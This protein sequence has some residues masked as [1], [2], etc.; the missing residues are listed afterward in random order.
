M[1]TITPYT[2]GLVVPQYKTTDYN[3]DLEMQLLVKKQGEYNQVMSTLN[4]LQNTSLNISMLNMKGKEKLDQY[5]QELDDLFSKDLGDLTDPAIQAKLAGYF[6]KISGDSDL[7]RRSKLSQHYQTQLN[8]IE[9]MRNAKNPAKSGYNAINEAVFKKWTGGLEDFMTADS[10]D[11]WES[12]MQSYTPFKDIDQKMVNLTKLLHEESKISQKPVTKKVTVDGKEY[13]VYTG[14]NVLDSETGVSPQRIRQLLETTLDGDEIAQLDVL[15]KYRILQNDTPEGKANLY[16]N[17]NGWLEREHKTT[18]RQLAKIKALKKQLDPANI[19]ASLSDDEKL[20]RKAQYETELENLTDQ[21]EYL[22]KKIT[23]QV[24]NQFSPTQWAEMS[25]DEILPFM[26]QLT[27]EN[28]VNGISEAL[29]WKSTIDK[30]GTDQTYFAQKRIENMEQ[31]L[32]LDEKLGMAKLKLAEMKLAAELGKSGENAWTSPGDIIKSPEE[33][34]SSWDKFTEIQGEYAD[35]TTPVV[36]SKD[37]EGNYTIDPKNLTSNSWIKNHADNHEVKLWS[38]YMS[39]YRNKGAFL[40]DNKTQPNIAG[41][42]LF[43]K[44]L[45]NGEFKNDKYLDGLWDQYEAEQD[46]ANWL[47]DKSDRVASVVLESSNYQNTTLPGGKYSLQDYAEANGWNSGKGEM[48]FGIP[49]GKGG[50]KQMT[51]TEVKKEYQKYKN[52]DTPRNTIRPANTTNPLGAL[53]DIYQDFSNALDP[54]INTSYKGILINDPEFLKLVGRAMEAETMSQETIQQAFVD[55]L[56]QWVQGKQQQTSDSKVIS[57]NI[58]RINEGLKLINPD[59]ATGL[60]PDDITSISRPFGLGEFGYFQVSASA[61]KNLGDKE[62][63]NNN[64]E[65]VPVQTNEWYRY[66]VPAVNR[67]DLIANAMF[68]DKGEVSRNIN[69]YKIT[70]SDSPASPDTFTLEI[71]GNGMNH[72]EYVAKKDITQIFALAEQYINTLKK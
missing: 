33:M 7:K 22:T 57:E 50:H 46:I 26:R 16:S 10:V 14:Y 38:A 72:S 59:F 11:N 51:W 35:R 12:V 27:I 71:T 1:P 55:E 64:G 69:G 44:Q 6:T 70:I 49:D 62:L 13:E 36:T 43:K 9:S 2:Q 58:I 60:N 19:P 63:V 47:N 30:I 41:F 32:A 21:E 5:N 53:E 29:S 23:Q 48:I 61:V 66:K 56:P 18:Q 68:E 28:Y 45:Q 15:T 34:F 67:R 3:S 17:Y 54:T 31:R 42:E 40:D 39:R 25:N 24:S 4:K 65:L 8:T 37:S 20:V 52:A